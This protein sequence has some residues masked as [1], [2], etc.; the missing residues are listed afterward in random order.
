MIADDLV[1]EE[2]EEDVTSELPCT[3]AIEDSTDFSENNIDQVRDYEISKIYLKKNQY[4]LKC[5]CF[6]FFL[7]LHYFLVS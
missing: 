1:T 6:F 5:G 3:L 2:M 7:N 4:M